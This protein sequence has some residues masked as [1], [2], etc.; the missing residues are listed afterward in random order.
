MQWISW[1][2]CAYKKIIQTGSQ[3]TKTSLNLKLLLGRV[4]VVQAE[5]CF[6]I[7]FAETAW[8]KTEPSQRG[9]LRWENF[10]ETREKFGSTCVKR[11][12]KLSD[13]KQIDGPTQKS[14]NIE[15]TSFTYSTAI[16]PTK[17]IEIV[18][19]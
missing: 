12:T 5:N 1:Q 7:I 17:S 14:V 19:E 11:L 10:S 2:P 6:Q 15:E 13:E 18:N 9:F 4:L 3:K 8:I 16:N